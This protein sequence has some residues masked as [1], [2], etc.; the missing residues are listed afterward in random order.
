MDNKINQAESLTDGYF[1]NKITDI[2]Q[3]KP[4]ARAAEYR[5]RLEVIM[6]TPF[7]LG[8]DRNKHGKINI[9]FSPNNRTSSRQLHRSDTTSPDTPSKSNTKEEESPLSENIEML[10]L[11]R[12][13]LVYHQKYEERGE[14]NYYYQDLERSIEK[15]HTLKEKHQA[16][17]TEANTENKPEPYLRI[18]EE[19]Q[20]P[21]PFQTFAQSC[22]QSITSPADE[23]LRL[24]TNI[25]NKVRGVTP[26]QATP[27]AAK[28]ETE[29]YE[30][31]QQRIINTL[32]TINGSEL[33]LRLA[34]INL[35]L[36][37]SKSRI[38]QETAPIEKEALLERTVKFLDI[39]LIPP[40]P[41]SFSSND[42]ARKYKDKLLETITHI[43]AINE[44]FSPSDS[45]IFKTNDKE[46]S[47]NALDLFK[48]LLLEKTL[49]QCNGLITVKNLE[50][51]A[52]KEFL[53]NSRLKSLLGE[54]LILE[55]RNRILKTILDQEKFSSPSRS[56][57]LLDVNTSTKVSEATLNEASDFIHSQDVSG[58]NYNQEDLFKVIL[59]YLEKSKHDRS[60]FFKF[61]SRMI[62]KTP[63]IFTK[64]QNAENS[65]DQF[66]K[67]KNLLLDH[68]EQPSD[69][70]SQDLLTHVD[71]GRSLIRLM[72]FKDNDI[73]EAAKAFYLKAI[74]EAKYTD[75][76]NA[77][78][79]PLYSIEALP[80]PKADKPSVYDLFP[81]TKGDLAKH[82][83]E[84]YLIKRKN[85][86]NDLERVLGNSIQQKEPTDD[87]RTLLSYTKIL[88]ITLNL[89]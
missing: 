33:N 10:R 25:L 8:T 52:K 22:P 28:Q 59:M 79:E 18:I 78:L 71:M 21:M 47:V 45:V 63:E 64:F 11:A 12:E 58:K 13:A 41:D 72:Q 50:L 37:A 53:D 3:A 55:L 86:I 9:L 26:S 56:G 51:P 88:D 89:N 77:L 66:R 29:S 36:Q 5:R 69:D 6:K 39:N 24:E 60:F 67:F 1:K 4:E 73:K 80:S 65:D 27:I 83:Q 46:S 68:L 48:K 44:Q 31:H 61:L 49:E 30:L 17:I 15:L 23:Y 40:V 57:N 76:L 42:K 85:T 54:D 20:T 74:K 38:K 87:E 7:Q 35:Y 14:R 2:M 62:G 32:K 16:Y 70:T 19:I 82:L 34:F 84:N 75:G 81:F 43:K